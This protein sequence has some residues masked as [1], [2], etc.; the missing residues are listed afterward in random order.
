M[1][2][3]EVLETYQLKD[4]EDYEKW[5]KLAK[6]II[7][8]LVEPDVKYNP[9]YTLSHLM[10]WARGQLL[11]VVP[12]HYVREKYVTGMLESGGGG[13]NEY[14]KIFRA[15]V[16]GLGYKSRLVNLKTEDMSAGHMCVEVRI[17]NYGSLDN[18]GAN[19]WVFFDPT[20]VC[21][22]M[23]GKKFLSLLDLYCNPE[24]MD[25]QSNKAFSN[26]TDDFFR[27]YITENIAVI[28]EGRTTVRI[29]TL[30]F[31]EFKRRFYDE[32]IEPE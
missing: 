29:G 22:Y 15:L 16:F 9:V 3:Q 31:K 21:V 6:F 12:E 26:R 13:C 2:D 8:K 20:Y 23:I 30:G 7:A 11:F 17:D 5:K 19:G 18:F 14:A 4:H 1:D 24:I 32:C 27:Q 25:I 10:V 28:I